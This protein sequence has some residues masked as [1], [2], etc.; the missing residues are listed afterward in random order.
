MHDFQQDVNRLIDW[1]QLNSISINVKKTKLVFHPYMQNVLNNANS[2]IKMY[3][4]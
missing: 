2:E 1:C 4:M 3:G